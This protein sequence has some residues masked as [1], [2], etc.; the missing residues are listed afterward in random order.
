MSVETVQFV[1]MVREA[2]EQLEG[3]RAEKALYAMYCEWCG[4][5]T[6]HELFTAGEWET[7]RCP[8]GSQRSFRVR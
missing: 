4:R 2:Y 7:Y 5:V 3:E 6:L 8:C 1:E